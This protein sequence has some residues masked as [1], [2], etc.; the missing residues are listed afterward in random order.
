M[1]NE[2]NKVEEKCGCLNSCAVVRPNGKSRF[3][4]FREALDTIGQWVAFGQAERIFEKTL[5]L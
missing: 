3:D 5:G 4:S 1:K 2:K